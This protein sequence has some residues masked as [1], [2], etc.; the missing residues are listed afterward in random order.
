MRSDLDETNE[1]VARTQAELAR[2]QRELEALKNGK[3]APIV[4]REP[5]VRPA[6]PVV[7]GSGYKWGKL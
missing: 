1:A 2:T 3:S 7:T 5:E 6:T 4:S